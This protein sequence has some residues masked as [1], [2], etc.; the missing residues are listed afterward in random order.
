MAK[1]ALRRAAAQGIE[2]SMMSGGRHANEVGII[3][4]SRIDDRLHDV[5]ISNGDWVIG[6]RDLRR[7]GS[8]MQKLNVGIYAGQQ[9]R[10]VRRRLNGT[11][12][13]RGMVDRYENAAKIDPAGHRIDEPPPPARKKERRSAGL[14]ENRLGNRALDQTINSLSPVGEKHDEVASVLIEK[15]TDLVCRLLTPMQHYIFYL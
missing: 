13:K 3:L 2:D 15:V 14:P 11:K 6:I 4:D 10:K 1:D 9:S 7:F 8:N 5:S 12:R